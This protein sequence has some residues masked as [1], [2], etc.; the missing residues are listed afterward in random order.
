MLSATQ[1]KGVAEKYLAK[2]CQAGT[3]IG[4]VDKTSVYIHIDRFGVI[5]KPSQPGEWMLIVDLSHPENASVND[6]IFPTLCSLSYASIDDALALTIDKG[7]LEKVH[8]VSKGRFGEC[9]SD[10]S[11]PS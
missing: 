7:S 10:D 11:S 1:N 6:D 8:S 9:I 2:E 3:V 4:P 5:P